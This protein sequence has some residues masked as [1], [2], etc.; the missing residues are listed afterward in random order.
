M[1]GYHGENKTK[2]FDLLLVYFEIEIFVISGANT[3]LAVDMCLFLVVV[4]VVAVFMVFMNEKQEKC[5]EQNIM[6]VF[7]LLHCLTGAWI[8]VK[9]DIHVL[10]IEEVRFFRMCV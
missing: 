1:T 7:L 6:I 4:F 5:L 10:F 9:C 2:I 8:W 3:W